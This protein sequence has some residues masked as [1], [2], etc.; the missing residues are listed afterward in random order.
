MMVTRIA[1]AL[2]IGAVAAPCAAQGVDFGAKAG[3]N[4]STISG[5]EGPAGG[6]DATYGR[7]IIG[8][9]FVAIPV[10]EALAIQPEV[11]LTRKGVTLTASAGDIRT[12]TALRLEYLEVPI[13][14][15]F[16]MSRRGRIYGLAGP[17]LAY[18]RAASER[19]E[20]VDLKT[21]RDVEPPRRFE[22]SVVAGA[23]LRLGA[24]VLEGRYCQGLTNLD[25]TGS[26]KTRLLAALV[27]LQF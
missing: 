9:L 10:V 14:A 20:A 24:F 25:E 27:G 2:L 7:N 21:E 19:I 18:L 3:L 12:R 1:L 6:L 4:A 17:A 16:A 15:R 5:Y 23:G 8:G 22:L 26:L 13:L 11:L